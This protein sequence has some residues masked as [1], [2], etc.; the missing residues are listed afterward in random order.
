MVLQHNREE[1]TIGTKGIIP[2]GVAIILSPTAVKAW[3]A[4][5]SKPPITTPFD[6][7]FVVRFVGV[8][9]RYLRINQYENK[10]RGNITLFVAS[11]YHPVDELEHTEFMDI[12]STIMSSVPK[13]SKFI[14]GHD[15]NANLGVGS[16]M[17][18]KTLVLWGINNRNMKGRRLLGFFSNNQLK[19]GNS[20]YKMSSYITWRSFNKMRSPQMLDV[21]SVSGNFFKCVKSCG[22]S[23]TGMKSDYSAVRLEFTNQSIKFKTNFFKKPVIDWKYIKEEDEVNKKFNVNLRNRLKTQSNY[24][25][26]N[27]AILRSGEETA[28]MKNS[29]DQGWYHFSRNTLTPTFEA[30][31]SVLHEI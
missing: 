11:I 20:F 22:I 29:E 13:K 28:M 27:D 6:S 19:V 9:L 31:N 16:K 8:K 18:G 25:E 24:T 12:L 7:S 3:R 2:G 21:I 10:V 23:K 17:Y 1:S 15:V 30:R 5:G 14:G 26:F 4:A